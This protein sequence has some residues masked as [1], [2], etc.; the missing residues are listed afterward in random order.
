M[1]LTESPSHQS[2]VISRQSAVGSR[3]SDVEEIVERFLRAVRRGTL[4]RRRAGLTFDGRP[5]R[6]MCA[7]V[8]LVFRR[9]ARG[10]RRL[11]AFKSRARIEKRTLNAAVKRDAALRARAACL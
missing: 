6:E 8:D 5:R 7:G 9:D 2:S 4:L 3:Q 10:Q 1:R 11:G